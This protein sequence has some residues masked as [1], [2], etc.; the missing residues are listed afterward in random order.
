[1]TT[2]ITPIEK[3]IIRIMVQPAS[4][5]RQYSE[6]EIRRVARSVARIVGAG[7]KESR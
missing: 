1:M 6:G 3:E 4:S 2:N 7:S 5:G